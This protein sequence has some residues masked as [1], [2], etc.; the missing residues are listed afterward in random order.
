MWIVNKPKKFLLKNSV[1]IEKKKESCVQNSATITSPPVDINDTKIVKENTVC[2]PVV[3]KQLWKLIRGKFLITF[4]LCQECQNNLFY[5]QEK[6][7][8]NSTG[9]T[10][11]IDLC[12]KCVDANCNATDILAPYKKIGQKRKAD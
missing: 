8:E 2:G 11:K 10:L 5:S 1:K 9:I 3:K 4:Y 7:G 6:F 12:N